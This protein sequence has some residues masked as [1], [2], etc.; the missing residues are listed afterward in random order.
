MT[1][2]G[3]SYDYGFGAPSAVPVHLYPPGATEALCG[4]SLDLRRPVEASAIPVCT[5]CSALALE[6]L[7]RDLRAKDAGKSVGS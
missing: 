4:S 6:K 5:G 1:S 7:A 3:E 2:E